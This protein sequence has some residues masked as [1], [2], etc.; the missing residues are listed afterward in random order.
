MIF[1]KII[2]IWARFVL[3][4]LLAV[5]GIFVSMS[6]VAV[7]AQYSEPIANILL[8]AIPFIV[9]LLPASLFRGPGRHR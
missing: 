5:L 2:K 6:A 4:A 3:S 9:I 1:R 8:L 7:I